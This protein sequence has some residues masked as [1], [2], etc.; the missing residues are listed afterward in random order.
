M[1]YKITIDGESWITEE[2]TLDEAC[3]VEEETGASWHTMQPLTSAKHAKAIM[4][5]FLAR[6]VGDIALAQ[7]RLGAMTV[8]EVLACIDQAP[9]KKKAAAPRGPKAPSPTSPEA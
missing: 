6:R 1:A 2:L 9:T 8:D 4:A 3:A 5:R 7:A